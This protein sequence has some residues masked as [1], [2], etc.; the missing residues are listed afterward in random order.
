[1]PQK[2]GNGF[3]S[4]RTVRHLLPSVFYFLAW[5]FI[6]IVERHQ[7]A[8]VD[9]AEL[10]TVVIFTVALNTLFHGSPITM[11]EMS[12]RIERLSAH[13]AH[14]GDDAAHA[15]GRQIERSRVVRPV[16]LTAASA[17]VADFAEV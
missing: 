7:L 10:L 8:A 4:F 16:R 3:P 2:A 17:V 14:R 6:P 9:L 13:I 5:A 11:I 15:L 1:M 12:V